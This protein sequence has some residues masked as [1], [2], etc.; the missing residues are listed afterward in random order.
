MQKILIALTACIFFIHFQSS[1]QSRELGIMVGVSG[2]KG[3]LNSK[4]FNAELVRPAIG[5]QYRRCYSNHWSFRAG[6]GLMKIKGDDALS[7]DTFQ[8]N[9]NLM[10]KSNIIEFHMGYEFNF[11]SYQTSNPATIFTPYLFGGIAVYRFNPKAELGGTWYALQPLHTEGQGT[12]THPDRKPYSRTSISIPFGGGFKFS[13]SR[14]LGVQLEA[15]VRRTYTDYLD[16]VS[17]TYA[18]PLEIRKEYGK[19]AG[20]LSDR[21]LKKPVSGNIGRQRGNSTDRDWYYFAG[22]QINYTLSKKYIDSCSPFR[23]KIH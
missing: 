7:E 2:Y 18:D 3:D 22:V 17:T 5:I 10:F 19:T 21:S 9:R 11:F 6:L 4:M 13:L 23:I 14:R 12:E 16:D 8:L 20:L 15:V 1:G